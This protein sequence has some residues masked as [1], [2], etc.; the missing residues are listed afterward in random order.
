MTRTIAVA[1]GVLALACSGEPAAPPPATP[2]ALQAAV[3][4]EP[5]QIRVGDVAEVEISVV[6]PPD[7][8]VPPVRPPAAV[9][10]VWLLGAEALPVVAD[11]ARLVHRTRIRIRA[12]ETGS[13]VWP[14][15]AV[16][17]ED[18]SGARTSLATQERPFAIVSMLPLAPERVDPFSYRTPATTATGLSPWLAAAAGGAAT[19]ATLALGLVAVRLRRRARDRAATR[20]ELQATRPWVEAVAALEAARALD[21]SA[22]REAGGAGAQ[23]L[24]RY[25]ARRYGIPAIEACPSEELAGVRPPPL[26]L[27]AR[28]REALACLHALDADRFRGLAT[29]DAAAQTQRALDAAAAWVRATVP[30]DAATDT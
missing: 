5:P 21:T 3:A 19:L 30:S 23:A 7:H 16:Q 15:V 18:A 26:L 12:R 1:L 25:V 28:W 6:T 17:V 10:G 20:A 29:P 27:T 9:D 4:I 24:R 13:F 8:R 22:W 11:G 2:V 14:A